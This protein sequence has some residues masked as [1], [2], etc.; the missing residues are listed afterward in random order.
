[1]AE[2]LLS[3]HIETGLS[4]PFFKF[5]ETFS[6][7]CRPSVMLPSPDSLTILSD[8][9]AFVKSFFSPIFEVSFQNPH[10]RPAVADSL[11]TIPEP[12]PVVNPFFEKIT[13]AKYQFTNNAF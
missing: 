12:E 5:F 2:R 3:Y 10:Q 7:A 6:G 1:V 9:Q 8:R 13:A 4:S 11:L